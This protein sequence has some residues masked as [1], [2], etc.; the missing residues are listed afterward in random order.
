MEQSRSIWNSMES[1]GRFLSQ[2]RNVVEYDGIQWKG[3]E[4]GRRIKNVLLEYMTSL[5]SI[6][7]QNRLEMGGRVEKMRGYALRKQRGDRGENGTR[8]KK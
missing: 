2:Q 1:Y 4:H 6:P 5:G 3:V 8:V 7:Q